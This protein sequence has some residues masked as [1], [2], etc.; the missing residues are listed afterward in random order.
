MSDEMGRR[1]VA[2]LVSDIDTRVYPVGRLIRTRRFLIMTND[3]RLS[4][5]LMHPSTHVPKHIVTVRAKVT[6]DMLV[7][8][9]TGVVIEGK[10][11]PASVVCY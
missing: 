10:N 11:L 7:T 3:G 1:C 8:L 5:A 4:N 6:E 2:E 9:S